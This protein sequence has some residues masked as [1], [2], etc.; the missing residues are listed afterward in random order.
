MFNKLKNNKCYPLMSYKCKLCRENIKSKDLY[1]KN[2]CGHVYDKCCYKKWK[3][4]FG[5]KPCC[6]NKK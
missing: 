3:R 5:M 6:F 4:M 1:K 2:C